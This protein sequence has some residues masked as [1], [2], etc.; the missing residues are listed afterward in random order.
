MLV[1]F[2]VKIPEEYIKRIENFVEAGI[3]ISKTEAIRNAIYDLIWNENKH[4]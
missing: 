2:S 3:Y 1:K 4:V